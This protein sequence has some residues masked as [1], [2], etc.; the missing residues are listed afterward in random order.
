MSESN[1][2]LARFAPGLP[3]I[4]GEYRQPQEDASFESINPANGRAQCTIAGAGMAEVDLAVAA[5]R[6]AFDEGPWPRMAPAQRGRI[7]LKLAELLEANTREMATLESLDTGKTLFDSGKIEIPFAASLYR[8]Y[9]GWAD[10]LGGETLPSAMGFVYTLRE[11][12]G[13]VG[14]ITPWNFP[15]LL[16]SWK[17]AP[18]LAAGCTMVLKP[19][20]ISSLTALRFGELC[21]E[22]GIP[23][24]VVNVL[25]GRGSVIGNGLV[26]H[27]GVDKIAFTG[28]TE[29]GR[30]I[31]ATAAGTMKRVSMELGGKSPNIVFEDADLKGALRGAL[32]GIFY[33]KGE[34]CAA[35]SRLLVQKSI[36]DDF[37]G[38][39]AEKTKGTT[40]GDPFDKATRMG[41]LISQDQLDG[42][43]GYIE[44]GK[45]DG[46]EVLVGGERL[47]PESGGYFVAPTV[48]AGVDNSMRIAREEIFGPVL[49]CIPF[50]DE[51]DALRIAN[52]SNYGLASAVWTR[53]VSRA[54]KMARGLRAGTV[55]I[56]TYNL[57]DPSAPFGG[58]KQ[59]G[60]G[61]ELGKD[62]LLAYTESK[63]VW[64][65]LD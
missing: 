55:W 20:Q 40:V 7:L 30:Q 59:S 3:F 17:L 9:G 58:F 22:A 2:P 8:Y 18:A 47:L 28:S 39:V 52:D 65:H 42:V 60:Y 51:A 37:V 13:V 29:V 43:L 49:S 14:M 5:A 35:G 31:V 32:T 25:P 26:E 6:R 54:H 11:P 44:S 21:N 53:D 46:A 64:T 56:N 16:A 33:N 15:F 1:D 61:R 50:E 41:P 4:D 10:K 12:V 23:E 36:Y 38:Q 48:F 27:A 24:G 63:T 19:A 45:S 34:V 62:G 57:Y